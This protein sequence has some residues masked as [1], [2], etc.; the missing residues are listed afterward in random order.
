MSVS[1]FSSAYTNRP[2]AELHN[3]RFVGAIDGCY[4]LPSRANSSDDKSIDEGA[5][6]FACRTQSISAE[7]AVLCARLR[8]S[9]ER[10]CR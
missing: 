5:R 6:V 2:A 7:G 10:L 9:L 4:S 1:L 8:A 3:I